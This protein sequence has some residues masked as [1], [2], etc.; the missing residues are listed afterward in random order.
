MCNVFSLLREFMKKNIILMMICMSSI[1]SVALQASQSDDL[2][3]STKYL[4]PSSTSRSESRNEDLELRDI[5]V[6]VSTGSLVATI[7]GRSFVQSP[8]I[9][10]PQSRSCSS[11][12]SATTSVSQSRNSSSLSHPRTLEEYRNS[13]M[14]KAALSSIA[15]D[16]SFQTSS[17]LAGEVIRNSPSAMVARLVAEEMISAVK[18]TSPFVKKSQAI[19]NDGSLKHDLKALYEQSLQIVEFLKL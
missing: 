11:V 17:A 18:D 15:S 7:H 1:A 16:N 12:P 19:V 10:I 14:F 6:S 5:H 4:K 8:L 13:P 9:S 3:L 2:G